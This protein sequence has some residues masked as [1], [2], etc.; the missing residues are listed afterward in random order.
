MQNIIKQPFMK[1]PIPYEHSGNDDQYEGFYVYTFDEAP[2]YFSNGM[3]SI[4]F[5]VL[6]IYLIAQYFKN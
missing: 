2:D 4:V 6:I 3:I 1:I 5:I